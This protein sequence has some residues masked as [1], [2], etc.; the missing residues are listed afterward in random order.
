MYRLLTHFLNRKPGILAISLHFLCSAT[1]WAEGVLQ[2]AAP[3]SNDP[4]FQIE[5]FAQA[6][7]IQTPV[8]LAVDSAGRVIVV[9]SNTHFRPSD[10][11]GP[12]KDRVLALVDQDC[13]GVADESTTLADGLTAALNLAIDSEDNIYVVCAKEVWVLKDTDNDGLPDRSALI[14]ELQTENTHPHNA[15]LGIEV[16][17]DGWLYL[18]RGNNS[19]MRYVGLGSDGSRIA[20]YGDGGAVWRCRMNGAQLHEVAT[21]FY[22]PFD[23]QMD[24]QGQL[25]ALDNDSDNSGLN[26]MLH[27]VV[28]GDYGYRSLY[29]SSSSHALQSW[30]GELPGSLS[31]AVALGEAPSGLLDI[32]YT[33]FPTDFEA[34]YLVALWKEN[35]IARVVAKPR[36]V[37][38]E[39]EEIPWI[40]GG[41]KFRPIALAA[42]PKGAVY[43]TDWGDVDYQ[44]HGGGKIWRIRINSEEKARAPVSQFELSALSPGMASINEILS[45]DNPLASTPL[46]NA[47]NS[48]DPFLRHISVVGMT[49]PIFNSRIPILSKYEQPY[50]RLSALLA[51]KRLPNSRPVR[52]IQEFLKDPD[53]DIRMAALIWA[54]ESGE[55]K[56]I[57]DLASALAFEVVSPDLIRVFQGVTELMNPEFQLALAQQSGKASEIPRTPIPDYLIEI[58][59]NER[60]P[61]NL[62]ALALEYLEIDDKESYVQGLKALS[63]EPPEILQSKAIRLLGLSGDPSVE[64]FLWQLVES[65]VISDSLQVECFYALSELGIDQ[66]ERLEPWLNRDGSVDYRIAVLECVIFIKDVEK[67]S[68]LIKK[69]HEYFLESNLQAVD[70]THPD[71][72]FAERL[73]FAL[74]QIDNRENAD[75]PGVKVSRPRTE[76]DWMELAGNRTGNL[77]R[78]ERLLYSKNRSCFTCHGSGLGSHDESMGPAL[79][80][81]GRPAGRP[82]EETAKAILDPNADCPPQY[83]AWF[84]TTAN[85]EMKTGLQLHHRMDGGIEMKLTNGQVERFDPE[86][87]LNYGALQTSSIMPVGLEAAFSTEEFLDLIAFLSD[88]KERNRATPTEVSPTEP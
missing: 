61:S 13:D 82:L 19:S 36:G 34:D 30:N 87:I 20:G 68:R 18:T 3:V 16:G 56:L 62:R 8:G 28:G 17:K 74:E 49:R 31:Y 85:E 37:S 84:V 63:V 69:L 78:G 77:M 6:P 38:F 53:E 50:V 10:Y 73:L 51:M 72:P 39:G 27:V 64:S 70:D 25:V 23:I 15:L 48:P 12:E 24:H 81:N 41:E 83:R 1:G 76:K 43:A 80:R 86:N 55:L 22:N 79:S 21:G 14:V 42:D 47:T 4:R 58:I 40:Q 7:E 65:P 32:A 67:K 44:N 75:L 52:L 35:R 9:Q 54:G 57:D 46:F 29:G 71:Y 60:R 33:A 88:P 5:I 66:T 45:I 2:T 59:K 26:R 11:A